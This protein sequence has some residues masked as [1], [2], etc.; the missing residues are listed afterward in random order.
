MSDSKENQ[1]EV[2]VSIKS[3][4]I[5]DESPKQNGTNVDPDE[6]SDAD[7]ESV[8][9]GAKMVQVTSWAGLFIPCTG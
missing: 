2:E 4:T 6:L 1:N 9:G 7:A 8:A 3:S 5:S